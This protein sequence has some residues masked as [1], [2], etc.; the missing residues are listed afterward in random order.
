MEVEV[1]WIKIQT[2]IFDDEKIKLIESMPE[3]DKILIIWLKLLTLAGKKNMDGY[4]SATPYTDEDLSSIFNRPLNTIRLALGIL[5]K[6]EMIRCDNN[7]SMQISNWDKHQNVEALGKIREQN[8]LRQQ[9]FRDDHPKL[10]APR[11]P[12]EKKKEEPDPNSQEK[13]SKYLELFF[14]KTT[15]SKNR[16]PQKVVSTL[17]NTIMKAV[18]VLT[19]T[20]YESVLDRCVKLKG[21]DQSWEYYLDSVWREAGKIESAKHKSEVPVIGK[22]LHKMASEKK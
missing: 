19:Q 5:K 20:Q 12:D 7:G 21:T 6:Y 2:G 4:I 14:Q 17:K 3:A 13:T 22:I 9:K 8:R 16:I 1:K 11:E 18:G 15:K 10:P